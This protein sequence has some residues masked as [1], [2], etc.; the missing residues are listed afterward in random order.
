MHVVNAFSFFLFATWKTQFFCFFLYWWNKCRKSAL[1]GALIVNITWNCPPQWPSVRERSP[2]SGENVMQGHT[3]DALHA[4]KGF[5]TV[6]PYMHHSFL[7][8]GDPL[9]AAGALFCFFTSA[10]QTSWVCNCHR[11]TESSLAANKG[12]F[13][14]QSVYQW[15]KSEMVQAVY[16]VFLAHEFS[17]TVCPPA[18]HKA[19]ITWVFN[20]VGVWLSAPRDPWCCWPPDHHAPTL[21][22][23]MGFSDTELHTSS[24]FTLR[25]EMCCSALL[26]LSWSL[27]ASPACPDV[28]TDHWNL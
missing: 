11:L 23:W 21:P 18:S 12:V 5:G 4:R 3:L 19:Q 17:V 10:P 15:L 2:S 13:W 1:L 20:W 16:L 8:A 26:L 14:G 6:S 7:H 24:D 25:L 27:D 9:H 28:E 22:G